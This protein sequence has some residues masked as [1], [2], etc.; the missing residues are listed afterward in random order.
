MPTDRTPPADRV[1]R[2]PMTRCVNAHDCCYGGAGA[3]CQWC[4]P[5]IPLRDESGRF[6]PTAEVER[7][8]REAGDAG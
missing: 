7:A 1:K 8:A 6:M 4:E 3:P 5:V 2:E